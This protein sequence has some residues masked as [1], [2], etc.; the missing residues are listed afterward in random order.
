M[1]LRFYERN[2][3]ENESLAEY[4]KRVN[5]EHDRMRDARL[6]VNI[7]PFPNSDWGVWCQIGEKEPI[8]DRG[9]QVGERYVDLSDADVE[10]KLADRA[11]AI[12]PRPAGSPSLLRP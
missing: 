4:Q 10:K 8:M 2:S 7:A 3:A 11:R 6:V 12:A 9:V 1:A 5:A